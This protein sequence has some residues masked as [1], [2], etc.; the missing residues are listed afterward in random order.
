MSSTGAERIAIE[1]HRQLTAEGWTHQHDAKHTGHEI[2]LAAIAYAASALPNGNAVILA[3]PGEHGRRLY[4]D[5][6]PW[7]SSWDKRP[8]GSSSIREKIRALEKAGALLAAEID[9]LKAQAFYEVA[10]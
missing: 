8:T 9:R 7:D 3:K 10:H 4:L 2:T 5:P 1:R 6:F